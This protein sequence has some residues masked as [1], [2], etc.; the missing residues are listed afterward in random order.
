MTKPAPTRA[1]PTSSAVEPSEPCPID[2][3]TDRPIARHGQRAPDRA[4]A[5]PESGCRRRPVAAGSEAQRRVHEQ[6][7]LEAKV[8]RADEKGSRSATGE[9]EDGQGARAARGGRRGRGRAEHGRAAPLQPEDQAPLPPKQQPP[10]SEA[11]KRR[12]QLI[13][14]IALK[15][16][17]RSG[18]AAEVAR[19]L[20]KVLLWSQVDAH[21][22]WLKRQPFLKATGDE[23]RLVGLLCARA[24][25]CR[26]L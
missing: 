12:A 19:R 6:G 3:L 7:C 2:R 10:N 26:L 15:A 16:D 4:T 20:D 5:A 8:G 17:E 18:T 14:Y 9:A 21:T 13:A 1:L 24:F 25:G 23:Q 11:E 22:T